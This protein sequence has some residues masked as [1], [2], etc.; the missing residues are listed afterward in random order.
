VALPASHLQILIALTSGD[1]HG[2]G[3]MMTARKN[4]ERLGP[5]A[6]YAA[7]GRL[8]DGGQIE[9]VEERRAPEL[10][11]DR[12]R[13]YRLTPRGRAALVL[14]LDRLHSI[15]ERAAM[16]GIDRRAWRPSGPQ[17]GTT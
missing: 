13:Y 12:R 14:E 4:G 3:I 15:L 10:D 16:A 8:I 5:G 17:L 11:D 7:I 2:Y 9:E 1:L 6:L